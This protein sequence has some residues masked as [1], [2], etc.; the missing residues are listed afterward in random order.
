MFCQ[1]CMVVLNKGEDYKYCRWRKNRYIICIECYTTKPI[2]DLCY[3]R[4]YEIKDV[5]R[6]DNEI[7]LERKGVLIKHV[8]IVI[9]LLIIITIV[10]NVI[11][12]IVIIVL[13][14]DKNMNM[15]LLLVDL[16]V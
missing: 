14:W 12:F 13:K 2:E 4:V 6:E 5:K 9:L 11:L 1:E 7:V 16:I 15:K 10:E 3:V 8:I